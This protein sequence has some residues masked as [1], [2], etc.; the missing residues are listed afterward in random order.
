MVYPYFFS[1]DFTWHKKHALSGMLTGWRKCDTYIMKYYSV[2]N[3]GGSSGICNNLDQP[4]GHKAKWQKPDRKT[5]AI[6]S[7]QYA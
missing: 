1:S 7:H 4:K 3:K 6:W 2:T 5:S